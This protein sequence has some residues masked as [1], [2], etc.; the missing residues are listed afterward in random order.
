MLS[1]RMAT[2]LQT[3]AESLWAS[4]LLLLFLV[5][6]EARERERERERESEFWR[7]RE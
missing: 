1:S 7:S 6:L 4:L 5:G 2:L 3:M